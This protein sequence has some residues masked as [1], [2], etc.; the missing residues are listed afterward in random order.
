MLFTNRHKQAFVKA[1]SYVF[2]PFLI[3]KTTIYT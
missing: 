2:L 1:L 3:F